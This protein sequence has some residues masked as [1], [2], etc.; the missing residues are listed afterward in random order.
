MFHS[1]SLVAYSSSYQG[2]VYDQRFDKSVVRALHYLVARGLRGVSC[3]I[4]SCI[5]EY[6]LS[7]EALGKYRRLPRK[8]RHCD[9]VDIARALDLDVG[10]PFFDRLGVEALLKIQEKLHNPLHLSVLRESVNVEK[11]HISIE[12][13]QMPFYNIEALVRAKPRSHSLY[14]LRVIFA[15][16]LHRTSVFYY[17][18]AEI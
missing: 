2:G 4:G 6:H 5:Y 10:E 7:A 18:P 13:A 8:H 9:G 16:S 15:K 14:I 1:Q 11:A 3:G 12:H 17:Y